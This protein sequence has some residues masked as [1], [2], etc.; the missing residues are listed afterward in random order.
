MIRDEIGKA[1]GLDHKGSFGLCS[2]ILCLFFL[3]HQ[4][5][6]LAKLSSVSCLESK[7]L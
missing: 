3:R 4:F 6:M 7:S 5:T 2:F 1:Q